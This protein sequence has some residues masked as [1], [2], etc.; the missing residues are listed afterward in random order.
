MKS[1]RAEARS[2]RLVLP[3][4]LGGLLPFLSA[5]S[6]DEPVLAPVDAPPVA[7]ESPSQSPA[8]STEIAQADLPIGSACPSDKWCSALGGAPDAAGRFLHDF[9]FA[10]Y[11]YG[12]PV[13]AD[14]PGATYDVVAKYTAD[15]TGAKDSTAAIQAAIDAASKAG[16][17]IVFF[18]KGTYRIDGR[19][20]VRASRVVLRGVGKES[21]LRFT[22]KSG[23][24]ESANLTFQGA[25]TRD[26]A[27]LFVA[28]ADAR[29]KE[30][31]V[32]DAKGLTP[33][34]DVAIGWTI[35][36]AFTAEHQM[37]GTWT[38]FAG[39]YEVFFRSKVVSVDGSSVAVDVPLRYRA[40]LRDGASIAR[41]SGYLREVGI[42]HLAVSN[43]VTWDEA[44]AET[45][46]DVI[47]MREVQ[48]AW[49]DDVHSVPD[50]T[51]TYHLRSGGLV[52]E[53]SK[54]V[55]VLRSSMASPQNRGGG[56]NGYLFEVS[57]T[58]EVLFA[59]CEGRD[60]RHNFIQNWGFGNSGT[61]FLRCVSSG[62]GQ[63]TADLESAPLKSYSEHHHSFGMATLVDDCRLDDGFALENRGEMSAGAG[64]TSTA[65]VVWRPWGTGK[66]TSKQ[67][68]WGY[69]VGTR[70][71]V[72]IDT[73]VDSPTGTATAPED[74]VEGRDMGD[75]LF[76]PS[77]YEHQRSVRLAKP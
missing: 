55:S 40:R 14:P 1:L 27:R 56:G 22:Q 35:T 52:I 34:D 31:R 16:G 65:S 36:P 38:A 21:H 25:V 68:G 77:L 48:D 57:R 51:T 54:R 7:K 13:P 32:A 43:A 39:T 73:R 23:L 75:T 12:D 60:G 11:H 9:S 67:F 5:C 26:A 66:V 53:K 69:V 2:S 72:T 20:T 71:G 30:V 70:K 63:T 62:G 64:H 3:S 45:H 28:D 19:L 74:F 41:E 61:V 10:G 42:E 59:D 49:V 18:P 17:G 44:W 29:A 4:I 47:A 76:P 58:S 6:Q 37:T 24:G 33:G 46:V 8:R 50:G 15:R